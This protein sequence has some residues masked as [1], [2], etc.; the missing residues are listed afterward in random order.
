[1]NIHNAYGPI[2][3]LLFLA[4][5]CHPV[6]IDIKPSVSDS[7]DEGLLMFTKGENSGID[8][9]ETYRVSDIYN[10]SSMVLCADGSYSGYFNQDKG[11]LY[12]CRCDNDGNA[13]DT[14]GNV[15]PWDDPAWF[16]KTD[17]DTRWGLRIR[18]LNRETYAT[19]VVCSPARRMQ[20]FRTDNGHGGEYVPYGTK[21]KGATIMWGYHL[22]NTEEF[23]ISKPVEN[24]LFTYTMYDGSYVYDFPFTLEDKRS[25]VSVVVTCGRLAESYLRKVHFKNIMTSTWYCP[26]SQTYEYPTMDLGKANA[27]DAYTQNSYPAEGDETGE[28]NIFC[29]PDG[30]P[31]I[32]LFQREGKTGPFTEW[33]KSAGR[34]TAITAIRDFPIFSLD[35]GKMDGDKYVYEDQ[36][37]EIVVYSGT[38]GCVKSTVRL[39]SNVE[40]MHKYTVI[41][42]ISTAYISAELLVTPWDEA[43][44]INDIQFGHGIPLEV[45]TEK[46]ISEWEPYDIPDGQGMIVDPEN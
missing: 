2:M 18:P 12:P 29:V 21:P 1:M 14:S 38:D 44:D 40:A 42:Y 26:K 15:I 11:W 36:I 10:G 16:E 41:V 22:D 45:D 9:V 13:L 24:K 6:S 39:A 34:G 28:G 7:G 19:L 31:D 32:H 4:G 3:A 33:S 5:A 46:W 35:Y 23:Y 37:P 25:M 8:K 43:A 17:K 27:Q 30:Q 20:K